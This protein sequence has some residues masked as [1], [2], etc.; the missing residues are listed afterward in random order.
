MDQVMCIVFD[1]FGYNN[2]NNIVLTLF[3]K[4]S[5]FDVLICSLNL[6]HSHGAALMNEHS[7]KVLGQSLL[8]GGIISCKRVAI[9]VSCVR[10][11]KTYP[12]WHHGTL[13]YKQL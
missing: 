9:Q 3:L 6:F 12:Y 5:K 13:Y 10:I 7:R 8:I 1:V 2:N 4:Q 11:S